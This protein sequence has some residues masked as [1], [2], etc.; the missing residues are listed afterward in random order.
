MSSDV[1]EETV[2]GRADKALAPNIEPD[3]G[4]IKEFCGNRTLSWHEHVYKKLTNKPT[5]HLIENILGIQNKSNQFKEVQ[6]LPKTNR[7][8]VSAPVSPQEN[9]PKLQ[10]SVEVNEPLNLSIRSDLKV[11]TKTVKGT[12]KSPTTNPIRI[13]RLLRL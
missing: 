1:K 6:D 12:S 8:T 13:N 4:V 3:G 9:F 5:P 10:P 11:R 7:M 2:D